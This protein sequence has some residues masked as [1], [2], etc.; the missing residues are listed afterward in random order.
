MKSSVQT[1]EII[2]YSI[3]LRRGRELLEICFFVC[4]F[5]FLGLHPQYMEVPR[6][7]VEWELQLL[8]Y[9]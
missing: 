8:A 9:A 5:V 6:L 1:S 2:I 7:G 4:F 3:I